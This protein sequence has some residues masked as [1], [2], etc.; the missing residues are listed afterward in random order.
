ML[1]LYN[2]QKTCETKNM[3]AKRVDIHINNLR[4]ANSLEYC[5]YIGDCIIDTLLSTEDVRNVYFERD[6]SFLL[7]SFDVKICK[8]S[9]Y[10]CTIVK[11]YLIS[12]LEK[13]NKLNVQVESK[14]DISDYIIVY[15]IQAQ[16]AD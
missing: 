9:D 14:E 15:T 16:S 4:Q 6:R 10:I 3:I 13:N 5:Y 1:F 7:I 11:E 2:K 12:L 8:T